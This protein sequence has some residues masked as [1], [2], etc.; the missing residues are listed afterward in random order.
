MGADHVIDFTKVD[1]VDEIRRITDG[2]GVDVAIEAAWADESVGQAAAMC[3]LGGRLVIVGIAGGDQL[4]LQAS[5]ARR[6]GLT[7]IMSRRM[8]H[9]YPRAIRLAA[10]HKVDLA[11]LVSHRF[12]LKNAVAAFRLNAAYRDKVSKV[13]IKS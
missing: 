6:K 11:G 5:V 3:R 1:P 9:T 13:M 4:S 2:R 10:D 12:A 8:K 7:I